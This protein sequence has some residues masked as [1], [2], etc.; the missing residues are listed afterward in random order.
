MEAEVLLKFV[1]AFVLVISLM[2][3]FS[4][5]MRRAGIA[6]PG[7]ALGAKRRLKVV[8][9]APLD[10]KRR[11][12]LVRRDEVEHLLVLGANGETVV[13]TGIPAVKGNVVEFRNVQQAE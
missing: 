2:L 3:L 7:L 4:Y 11:L 1:F 9:V 12:V 8:E 13:E 10:H 5:F 6:G